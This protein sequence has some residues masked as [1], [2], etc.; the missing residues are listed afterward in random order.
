MFGLGLNPGHYKCDKIIIHIRLFY[1]VLLV[2]VN[3]L[4]GLVYTEQGD[5]GGARIYADH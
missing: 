2:C 1:A 5:I 4:K 3:G